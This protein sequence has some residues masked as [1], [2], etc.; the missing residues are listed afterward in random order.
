M[1]E[2]RG[3]TGTTAASSDEP[4]D[5]SDARAEREH[6]P[7]GEGTG[8][9]SGQRLR[10]PSQHRRRRHEHHD[11]EPDEEEARGD[12]RG[13]PSAGERAAHGRGAEGEP[14]APL[15]RTRAG[16]HRRADGAGGPHDEERRRDRGLGLDADRVDEHRQRED[17]ASAAEHPEHDADH[18]REPGRE[19]IRPHSVG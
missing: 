10:A 4:R 14:D 9:R 7:E 15:H 18:Q 12:E 3:T 17:G 19:E 2:G 5:D 8:G 1:S 6:A 11:R 16:V 13:E